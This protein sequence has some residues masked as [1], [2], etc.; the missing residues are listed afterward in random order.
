VKPNVLDRAIGYVAP[1]VA[2]RRLGARVRMEAALRMF[3]GGS[4][5]GA[6]HDTPNTKE[7]HPHLDG[8]NSS[9]LPDLDTLR[10]DCADL[11]ANAPIATGVMNTNV[12]STVG[13]GLLPYAR[14][15]REFLKLADEQADTWESAAERIFDWWAS[16]QSRPCDLARRLDFYSMQGWCSAPRS[17]AATSSRFVG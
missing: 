3:G 15:D 13:T 17:A 5:K 8:P 7:W 4:Y 11:E 2:L 1:T 12:T 10:A 9:T 16:S 6:R 14:V